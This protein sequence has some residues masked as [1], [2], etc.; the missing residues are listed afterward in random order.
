MPEGPPPINKTEG[1]SDFDLEEWLA[2][3]FS[4][5]YDEQAK[6]LNEL[7]IIDLLPEKQGEMGF[8]GIDGEE[9]VIPSKE[10]IA[11]EIRRN[12]EKYET[13]IKQG[14]TELVLVPFAT[15][16]SRL[17]ETMK[18]QILEHFKRGEV[19][20]SVE[21]EVELDE[22]NS[23]IIYWGE[24]DDRGISYYPR[25]FD[26]QDHQ[27]KTKQQILDQSKESDLRGW[28][29]LLME[30]LP[31]LPWPNKGQTIGG[32]KQIESG[33]RPQEY[34]Q[35]L[36]SDPQ[37][38]HEQGLTPEDWVIIFIKYLK[39]EN[40]VIDE[41]YGDGCSCW[42]LGIYNTLQDKAFNA[43]WHIGARVSQDTK[44]LRGEFYGLRTVVRIGELE[45]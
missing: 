5:Q 35:L 4:R 25:K 40:R 43:C 6:M 32:R 44:M 45:D 28:N 42:L 12:S 15:S 34:L 41:M 30:D 38:Q 14:F 24:E 31:K 27:G 17:A 16:I 36:E 39:K 26:A 22:E 21:Q 10:V 1:E 23:L 19:F 29:I 7:N 3:E 11:D 33:K 2:N 18:D 13:K 20:G 8:V 37:Y 9:Y